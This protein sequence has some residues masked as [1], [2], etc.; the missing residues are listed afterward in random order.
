MKN[1]AFLNKHTDVIL[2][3]YFGDSG[4]SS[5]YQ[6]TCCLLECV[7]RKLMKDL[8]QLNDPRLYSLTI[9]EVIIFNKQ[10]VSHV[11]GIFEFQP[12]LNPI[13]VFFPDEESFSRFSHL[14]MDR[15]NDFV[16]GI[17]ES[18][19]FWNVMENS[20]DTSAK[21]IVCEAADK[22]SLLLQS[23]IEKSHFIPN[24]KF[25]MKILNLIFKVMDDFRLRL[26]QLIHNYSGWPFNQKFYSI[27][28]TFEFFIAQ[29]AE[30]EQN[31]VSF[32]LIILHFF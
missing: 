3:E 22:F 7:Q 24:K 11:P 4:R 8:P 17:F 28:N 27:L 29:I 9:D 21:F 6:L 1:S 20:P 5:K 12:E 10:I 13:Q 14:L 19:V 26:T 23:L 18:D 32:L 2:N 31:S 16:E 30:W 15:L 25:K